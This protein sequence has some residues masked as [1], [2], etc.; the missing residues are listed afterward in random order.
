MLNIYSSADKVVA[1]ASDITSDEE[2]ETLTHVK[3]VNTE[4][5]DHL[6]WPHIKMYLLTSKSS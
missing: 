2:G 1:E 4:V 3:N 5:L 6:K